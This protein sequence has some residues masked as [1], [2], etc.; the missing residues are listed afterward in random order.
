MEFCR[1]GRWQPAIRHYTHYLASPAGG[2]G[3]EVGRQAHGAGKP[4]NRMQEALWQHATAVR[5]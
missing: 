2:A 3:A 4:A 5:G 1:L